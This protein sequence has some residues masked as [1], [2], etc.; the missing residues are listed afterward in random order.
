MRTR[1]LVVGGLTVVSMAL[2]A[3]IAGSTPRPRGASLRL[4]DGSELKTLALAKRPTL[5]FV[6]DP[7]DCLT[8]DP[9]MESLLDLRS[10]HAEQVGVVLTRVPLSRERSAL[11][12]A[13]LR[14]MGVLAPPDDGDVLPSLVLITT[15]GQTLTWRRTE[16]VSRSLIDSLL[17]VPPL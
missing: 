6:V 13:R 16:R 10:R 7:A 2:A 12:F 8:C 1:T 5:L 9:T 3:V 17:G 4:S 15:D 11:S 14:V